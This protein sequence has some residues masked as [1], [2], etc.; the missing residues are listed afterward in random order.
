MEPGSGIQVISTGGVN[1]YRAFHYFFKMAETRIVADG[2]YSYATSQQRKTSYEE[3]KYT[4]FGAFL[5]PKINS[6]HRVFFEFPSSS[7]I[8]GATHK[9][10]SKET[11][12]KL[13]ASS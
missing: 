7:F 9:I 12:R 5:T 4:T 11:R 3:V 10:Y 6:K 1:F 2:R 13:D 8:E